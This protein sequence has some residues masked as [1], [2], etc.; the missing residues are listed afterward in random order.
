M[1]QSR[2]RLMQMSS[3]AR[4]VAQAK[5]QKQKE[6]YLSIQGTDQ[7]EFWRHKPSLASL[8]LIHC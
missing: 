8:A 2:E 1:L 3:P 5:I 4:F 6:G 7:A